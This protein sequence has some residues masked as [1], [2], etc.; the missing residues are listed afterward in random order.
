M[1]GLP[2]TYFLRLAVASLAYCAVG[3]FLRHL[4][5]LGILPDS[6]I[7]TICVA[8]LLAGWTV[9]LIVIGWHAVRLSKRGQYSKSYLA[10]AIVL[11]LIFTFTLPSWRDFRVLVLACS[12][13]IVGLGAIWTLLV[14]MPGLA[15]RLGLPAGETASSQGRRRLQGA[16]FGLGG[17]FLICAIDAVLVSLYA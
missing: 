4:P 1:Q 6:D 15:K 13:A 2:R 14:T 7:V 5:H 8:V 12:A 16:L 10:D 3:L 17:G 11:L 9:G